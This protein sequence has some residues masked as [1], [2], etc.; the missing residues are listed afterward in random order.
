MLHGVRG[1]LLA[2]LMFLDTQTGS[3]SLVKWLHNICQD[4]GRFTSAHVQTARETTTTTEIVYIQTDAYE[5]SAI[6]FDFFLERN[7]I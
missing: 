2:A 3:L 7:F 4:H 5:M 1:R 6:Y